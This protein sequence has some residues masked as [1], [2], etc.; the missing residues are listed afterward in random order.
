MTIS[1][2]PLLTQVVEILPRVRK[3]IIY[4][5][6]IMAADGLATQRARVSA[7]MISTKLNR[8]NSAPVR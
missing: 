1:S 6:N 5:A 3:G 2:I 4:I 7:T 8:D